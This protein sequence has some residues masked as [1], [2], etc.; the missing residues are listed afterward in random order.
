MIVELALATI[1]T[2]SE[3]IRPIMKNQ[4]FRCHGSG[5]DAIHS[6]PNLTTYEGVYANRFKILNR[7]VKSKD[8][9]PRIP[10][11]DKDRELIKKWVETGA[12]R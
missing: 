6:L 12:M 2:Y 8:M 9:P 4:C 5:Q 11:K 1:I 10:M 3:H 7:V